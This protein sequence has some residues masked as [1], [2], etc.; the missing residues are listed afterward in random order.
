MDPER[1]F[2][3]Y[4]PAPVELPPAP[5][6]PVIPSDAF[7]IGDVVQLK[8]GGPRMTVTKAEIFYVTAAYFR[9]DGSLF[10]GTFP[11]DALKAAPS[12]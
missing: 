4:P 5:G 2:V 1:L 8:S 7:K 12:S 3:E 6:T 11:P 9:A 10:D